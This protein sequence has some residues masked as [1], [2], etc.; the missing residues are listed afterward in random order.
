MDLL[1]SGAIDPISCNG[2]YVLT[3]K[4]YQGVEYYKHVSENYWLEWDSSEW[5][6]IDN[7]DYEDGFTTKYLFY[8]MNVNPLGTYEEDEGTGTVVVSEY[9]V[10][11]PNPPQFIKKLGGGIL[12]D[13]R[14]KK[15]EEKP[16]E[17][18]RDQVF[19]D[20]EKHLNKVKGAL[21]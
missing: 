13:P 8:L 6:I 9:F 19:I 4:T 18:K 11:P 17:K 14:K 21:I 10:S 16:V 5:Y 20:L 2:R 15:E 12:E 1:V 3:G 7:E